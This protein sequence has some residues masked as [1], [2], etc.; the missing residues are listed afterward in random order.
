MPESAYERARRHSGSNEWGY[1]EQYNAV[2]KLNPRMSSC[3]DCGR[4]HEQE[5]L[6]FN[7]KAEDYLCPTCNSRRESE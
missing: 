6:T 4:Y 2:G 1:G 5:E 3:L 7:D